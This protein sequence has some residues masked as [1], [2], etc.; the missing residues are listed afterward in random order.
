MASVGSTS[1]LSILSVVQNYASSEAL[2]QQSPHLFST[3]PDAVVSTLKE[4]IDITMHMSG[5]LNAHITLP[6]SN[7]KL[8]SLLRQETAITHTVHNAALTVQQTVTALRKRVNIVYGEDIPP[9][10]SALIGW[11]TA[12][13]ETWGRSAGMEAFKEEER[14][15]RITIMLGGKVIVIDMEL[16]VNRLDVQ[17]PVLSVTSVKTSFAVPNGTSSP[18]SSG[19]TSLDGFL[20][21]NL[22]AFIAE[23]QRDPEDQDPEKAARIGGRIV[24]HLTYLMKMDQLALREGDAGLRWFNGCDTLSLECERYSAEECDIVA[25]DLSLTSAPLDIFLMRAHALPLPY[26]TIP[27]L[28]FLIHMS[29]QAYLTVLRAS[30]SETHIPASPILPQVDVEFQHL[31][32]YAGAHPRK[33]GIAIAS[34]VLCSG[35]PRVPQPPDD[36]SMDALA[37]RPTFPLAPSPSSSSFGFPIAHSPNG[38]YEAEERY[39]LDFTDS[40]KYPGAVMSQTRMHE[41]EMILHPLAGID[42]IN[43]VQ[44]LMSFGSGS[45]VDLLLNPGA[46]MSS[47]RYTSLYTSPTSLH[48]PLQLKLTAPEEPGFFLEKVPVRNMKEVWA[49]LEVVREQSWINETLLTCQWVPE[50]LNPGVL[51]SEPGEGDATEDELHALLGGTVVPTSIPVNVYV[52]ATPPH[53]PIFDTDIDVMTMGQSG[54]HR[55]AKIVMTS[56]E[57]PPISGLVEITVAHD[58]TRPR[59]IAL[60]INGAMGADLSIDTLEEVCRRGGLLGLPGRVWAKAHRL[61]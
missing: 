53:D 47:E 46:T 39:F 55:T 4:L 61:S 20:T 58:C 12:R 27:S 37:T 59:G 23:V 33:S 21:E 34:L 41:I 31:R 44:P 22:R 60:S 14:D 26:L 6:L 11:C 29:P 10:K 13:V 35:G 40:G 30:A 28:S 2:L 56:P 8:Y 54:P 36:L 45:W 16:S 18:A 3:D 24:D 57:Q 19:S 43:N 5:S 32:S 38:G 15:G 51:S 17:R 42:Q 9:E 7:P 50:L 1:N 48:P 25:K 52:P 49:I